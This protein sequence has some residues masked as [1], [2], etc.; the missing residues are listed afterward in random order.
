MRYDLKGRTILV[1]GASRGIGRALALGFARR[2]ARVLANGRDVAALDDLV[3]EVGRGAVTALPGDLTRE[4]DARQVAASAGPVDVLV[5]NAGVTF[6]GPIDET[7]E[8]ELRRVFETNFFAMVRLTKLV[9]PSMR[10]RRSGVV[11]Q[12]SSPSGRRGFPMVGAYSASKGAMNAWSEAL[13]A[14]AASCGV[15]VVLVYPDVT[16]SEL[17]VTAPASIS[18]QAFRERLRG[19][20]REPSE[21]VAELTVR[22]VE[23]GR[24][25]VYCTARAR[26][27]AFLC[28]IAPGVL[29]W[30]VARRERF[31]R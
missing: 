3:H 14:E 12:I 10:E 21:K 25:E 27:L 13:R 2:G 20:E 24:T 17:Y 30:A 11:V 7:P 1:T 29:D 15:R 5:N 9:L 8:D 28:G 31:S 26:L 16:T 22:A 18:G 23:R 6:Y 4:E 19:I